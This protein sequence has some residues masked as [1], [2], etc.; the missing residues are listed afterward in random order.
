MYY[1]NRNITYNQITRSLKLLLWEVIMFK[2][3]LAVLLIMVIPISNQV[4]AAEEL[5]SPLY[6]TIATEIYED[7]DKEEDYYFTLKWKNPDS[8]IKLGNN[9]NYEVDFKEGNDAWQSSTDTI[10]KKGHLQ[11]DG[12]NISKIT[13]D[14]LLENLTKNKID[15][16]NNHYSFRIRYI[17]N[18]IQGEF[19]NAVIA[20][21]TDYYRNSSK[22]AE[23][24]LDKALRLDFITNAIRDDMTSNVTR[25]EF[26]EILMKMY[27]KSTGKTV[28]YSDIFFS[29]T[30]NPEVLKAAELGI[31]TGQGYG[32]F[33]PN[34]FVTRQEICTMIY[35]T[36]KLLRPDSDFNISD[37]DR[38]G[39]QDNIEQ[40]A[41]EAMKYMYK[42]GI[43]K[44]D[45]YGKIDPKGNSSREVAT[46]LILR[47]YEKFK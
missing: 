47:T 5:D 34:D 2:K 25:E 9:V 8:I 10:L 7:V 12:N 4:F 18:E 35:R 31:V 41:L 43:L 29:D 26:S 36:M 1:I 23:D 21:I 40:W 22:W 44:G 32:L 38:F 39:D 19:S 13:F 15:I 27:V 37:V 14:P 45:G 28:A 11:W 6:I 3:I 16:K 20:G 42:Q 30:E 17:F 46:I 33:K 24:E